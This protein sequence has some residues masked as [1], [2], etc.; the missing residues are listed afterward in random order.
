MLKTKVFILSLLL[1]LA[2]LSCLQAQYLIRYPALSPDGSRLAFSYQGD[3]W[4]MPT[5]GGQ[6]YRMTI[7]E[8]Y[9]AMPK[10][11]PDGQNIAF[12]GNRF[13]NNDLFVMSANSGNPMRITYN[14]SAETLFDWTSNG[15]LLF[16]TKGIFAEV[17]WDGEIHTVSAKGGTPQRLLDAV[18]SHASMSPDGRFIAFMRGPNDPYRKR[19]RGYA[20]K[21]IWLYDTKNKTYQKI[22]S[23]EGNCTFPDWG[24]NRSLY[25]ISE[26]DETYNIYALEV[27]EKGTPST[28]TRQVTKLK[29]DGVRHFDVTPDGKQ[30]VFEADDNIY[31][32]NPQVSGSNPQALKLELIKDERFDPVENKTFSNN[33]SEYAVNPSEKL[34]ALVIRG[35]IFITE[36]D[37]EKPR[38]VRLTK[39]AYYDRDIAWLS[40]SVLLF[41]SDREG[42]YDLYAVLSD[43]PKESNLFKTLKHKTVRLTNTPDNERDI[44][45]SPSGKKILFMR[46]T[47]TLIV[48][49]IAANGTIEQEKKLMEGW[50]NPAGLRVSPDSK[51]LTFSMEDLNFNEE[52][53]IMPIDGSAKPLNVSKHP[54][55]DTSP[56]WSADGSKLVF[57]SARNNNDLNLWFVWLKKA[58]A[59]KTKA[60][61]LEEKDAAKDEPKSD[62]KPELK[63]DNKDKKDT[64]QNKKDKK[65]EVKP[66]VIDLEDISNRVVQ[67]TSLPGNETD[68][69][70]SKDGKTFYFVSNR[71]GRETYNAQNDLYSVKWTGE[72]ITAL[73][74]GGQAPYGVRFSPS[75]KFLYMMKEGGTIQ[76]IMAEGA[77]TEPVPFSASMQINHKQELEQMFEEGWRTMRDFFYDPEYHGV[78]WNGIKEKYKGWALKASTKKDFRDVFNMM[79]G[80]LNA[81]HLGMYG[82]DREQVQFDQTG[83]LG[84]EIEPASNGVRVLRVL[85]GSPA[86]RNISKLDVG[87]VITAI[88][89]VKLDESQNF[90]ALLNQT[91]NQ[92]VLLN[93]SNS[94]GS[95]REVVIRPVSNLNDALYENWINERKK[96]AD[97]YSKGKVG[98]IHIQG[99]DWESYERFERELVASCEGKEAVVI[100]VRFNGG[101]WTT[102][103]L[104]SILS[105][106]QHAYTIPR[107]AAKD[108]EKEKLKFKSYYP[109]GERLPMPVVLKPVATLCNQN[110]YSN[111]EIFSHAFKTL[112]MGKLVGIPTF[113][114][115]IS[116]GGTSMIDGS[117]LRLPYRGWFTVSED[118]NMENNGAVPDFILEND[119]NHKAQQED[120]QLKKAVEELLKEVK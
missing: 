116:T 48:A 39:H 17:E 31:T 71:P 63:S 94:G 96:L 47:G 110:S 67:V 83:L 49:D 117:L 77:K 109:Y 50:A 30:L 41:A 16:G 51:W 112:K 36:N 18:G 22:T 76:R 89:G 61:W 55:T 103:Y 28:S 73:T 7:H 113:G 45:I 15:Q 25:F 119:P 27:D 91:A 8:A 9:E 33:A 13:G 84:I 29:T 86:D 70:V 108:L 32:I 59:E 42:Q 54:R 58:D 90:Y 85:K 93:V 102:D 114:A 98:Y 74:Q 14:S 40:D 118:K 53:Y 38:G 6:A 66:L 104:M 105:T 106:K 68:L 111:A 12:Q 4:Q 44:T 87:D 11:S 107:G 37:K 88:N 69:N 75:Y 52:V 21:Q 35:E 81:S 78:N 64:T 60:E 56:V 43:D 24:G 80:E 23:F 79:L 65:E 72:E 46:G 100:D 2:V 82:G 20:N 34:M 101:G 115:V 19:Y 1:S 62:A 57:L 97:K 5:N 92:K 26:I 10:W 95:T 3:I 120:Q 99:M